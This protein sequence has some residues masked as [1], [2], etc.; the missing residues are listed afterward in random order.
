[1]ALTLF[2]AS[3]LHFGAEDRRALDW[4]ARHG[5]VTERLMSDNGSAYKSYLFADLLRERAVKHVRTRPSTLRSNGKAGRFHQSSLREWA[6]AAPYRSSADRTR[7]I[8]FRTFRCQA[9]AL[10]RSAS[11]S[12]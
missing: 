10:S 6:Y 8:I 12:S 11:G 2:H 5:V 1:M 3:D 9:D 4:F 7:A